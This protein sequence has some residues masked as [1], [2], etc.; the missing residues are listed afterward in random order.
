[1]ADPMNIESAGEDDDGRLY[2][3]GIDALTGLPAVPPMTEEEAARRAAGGLLLAEEPGLLHRLW[4]ALKRPF[5]GLPDDVEPTDLPAVGWAVV[6]P[7]GT[8]DDVR[9]AID[10]L[11]VHR[12]D[13]TRIPADRCK[14]L[15]YRPGQSLGDWLRGLGAHLADVEPTRLPYYVTLVGGPE[16]ISFEFQALLDINY[17][18]GRIAFDRPEQ[19]LR[20]VEGLIAYETAAVVPNGRQVLYW[21]PRNRADRATQLS[22]DC[23]IRP[24][25]EGIPA[26]GDQPAY[27]AIAEERRFWSRCLGGPEATRANLLEALFEAQPGHRPAFLFTASHGLEWPRGD[28]SQ[29]AE[30]GALLCQDWPGLGTPPRPEHCL[31]AADIGD[32]AQFHGLVAFL[33]AC[34]GAG[35]PA[36]DQFL[37]DRT[38]DPVPIADRPFVAALPQRLLSHPGGP[39]L[40]AFGHVERA[41]GYSIR[42]RGLGPRLRPFRNLLS[43]VL[44]GEP[45]GHATKD[46][47]DR[48]TASSAQLN[49]LLDPSYPGPRPPA[50]EVAALWVECNDARNYVLLG[51]PAARLRVDLLA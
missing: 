46:L 18:V 5:H 20:Y 3:N 38:K 16:T 48:F 36:F 24:L 8:P 1:M 19:Y 41:W 37:A 15:D 43:R 9:R 2:L 4:E 28:A 10:R 50:A 29:A 35:T 25:F 39:A 40:V 30:Q 13:H 27:A 23:L 6:L 32:D 31:R 42:P 21:G 26:A 49:L 44:K 22:A 12:R 11:V 34:H 45:V 33:F 7:V 14:V 47:S 17:A 51:D